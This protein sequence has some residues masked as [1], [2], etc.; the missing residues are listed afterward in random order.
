MG[1][2]GLPGKRGASI[3]SLSQC[4]LTGNF[5]SRRFSIDLPALDLKPPELRPEP[6]LGG[7]AQ[8]KDICQ[9]VGM[10]A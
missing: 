4:L 10:Q 7:S 9:L 3:P 2:V 8:Q 6:Y 1:R 5:D